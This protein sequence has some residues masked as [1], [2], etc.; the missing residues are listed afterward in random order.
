[1]GDD[2]V[3]GVTRGA[4]RS[5]PRATLAVI[6]TRPLASAVA[7][8]PDSHSYV[9]TGIDPLQPFVI[10]VQPDAVARPAG[11]GPVLSLSWLADQWALYTSVAGGGEQLRLVEVGQTDGLIG[12]SSSGAISFDAVLVGER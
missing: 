12:I 1:M 4:H 8:A 2:E 10:G 7:W 11:T 5:W 6:R 3:R 9:C